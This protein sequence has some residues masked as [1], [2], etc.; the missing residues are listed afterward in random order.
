MPEKS[1]NNKIRLKLLTILKDNPEMSQRAMMQ[2]MGISLGKVNYCISKLSEHGLIK[3]E[4]FKK[5]ENKTAYAYKLTPGGLEELA[6]LTV[7]FLKQKIREHNQ[8]KQEIKHLSEQI[9]KFDSDFYDSDEI[10][11]IFLQI[12]SFT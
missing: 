5:S 6:L 7:K 8:I 2:E 3:I 9:E 12:K 11:D 1:D 4:R 10:S